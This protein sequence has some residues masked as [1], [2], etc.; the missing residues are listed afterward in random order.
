M[1]KVDPNDPLLA[2][3][4]NSTILLVGGATKRVPDDKF[5]L[6]DLV[7]CVNSKSG[8]KKY[9]GL[10]CEASLPFNAPLPRK[11]LKFCLT[12]PRYFYPSQLKDLIQKNKTLIKE[13]VEPIVHVQYFE[14]RALTGLAAVEDLCRYP[15]KKLFMTGF[16]F[17]NGEAYARKLEVQKRWLIDTYARDN[18]IEIDEV[19]SDVLFGEKE[20]DREWADKM[21]A[22]ICERP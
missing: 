17:Y 12:I 21:R 18:R 9:D 16:D 14:G 19:L 15:I 8:I 11:F 7:V 3:L 22:G 6:F 4:T 13:M 1:D 20:E 2:V 5:G 10:Y